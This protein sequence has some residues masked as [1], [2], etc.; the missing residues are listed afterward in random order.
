MIYG[1]GLPRTATASLAK[2]FEDMGFR[3]SHY[4]VIHDGPDSDVN[5]GVVAL[6]NNSFY[7]DY[8]GLASSSETSLFI[9]TTRNTSDWKESI[10]RFS[11][12]P[13]DLPD[14]EKY[15]NEVQEFFSDKGISERLLVI[16]IFEDS[17]SL[18][19]TAKFVGA[20]ITNSGFPHVKKNIRT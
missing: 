1:I 5:D 4:C 19:K 17:E 6:V 2:I 18:E 8:K 12:L 3:S 13:S 16:N 14:V 7:R 9:L 20:K 11:N 10:S 15:E